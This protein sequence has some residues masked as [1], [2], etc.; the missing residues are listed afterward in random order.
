MLILMV[1]LLVLT[2]KN[3]VWYSDI[4]AT[5]DYLNSINSSYTID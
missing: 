2:L 3:N 1:L 4:F 5:M